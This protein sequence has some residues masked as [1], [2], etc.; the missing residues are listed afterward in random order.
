M[1]KALHGR[2]IRV[3]LDAVFH[4]TGRDFFAFRDILKRGRSSPD[5]LL[6]TMPGVPAIYFGSEWGVQGRKITPMLR[7]A[8]RSIRPRFAPSLPIPIY[9]GS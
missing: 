6:L 7:Y 3:L 2:G 1:V 8:R 5:I 4:H 9:M